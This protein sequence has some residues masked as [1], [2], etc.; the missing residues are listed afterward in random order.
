M[1]DCAWKPTRHPAGS[2]SATVVS[3]IS[4]GSVDVIT[5]TNASSLIGV[6]DRWLPLVAEK[7]GLA[8]DHRVLQLEPAESGAGRRQGDGEGVTAHDRRDRQAQLVEALRRDELT[9]PG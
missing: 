6:T 3:T 9:E 2:S 5:V 4:G 8:V 7:Q 1:L